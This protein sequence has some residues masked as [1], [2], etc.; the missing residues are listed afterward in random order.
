MGLIIS[1][2]EGKVMSRTDL[3]NRI[4]EIDEEVKKIDN[5][6]SALRRR[7]HKLLE[8]KEAVSF[9]LVSFF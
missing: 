8:D 5:E 1:R 7:K 6:I 3:S 9:G 4:G 2:S